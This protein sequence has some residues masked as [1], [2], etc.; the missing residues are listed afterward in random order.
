MGV[1]FKALAEDDVGDY[2]RAVTIS[3]EVDRE[4]I[5][6]VVKNGGLKMTLRKAPQ[7]EVK[8]SPSGRN[9]RAF[10]A[11]RRDCPREDFF[12][13]PSSRPVPVLSVGR[14][15]HRRKT[16]AMSRGRAGRFR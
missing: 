2:E 16:I 12:I 1:F 15:I 11:P 8:K 14:R 3:D 7:A 5:G 4:R 13:L 9:D 10:Y 6:A